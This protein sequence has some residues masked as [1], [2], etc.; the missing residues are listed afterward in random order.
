MSLVI[1]DSKL[2]FGS[3]IKYGKKKTYFNK[4]YLNKLI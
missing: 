1:S 3:Q 4:T 2:T